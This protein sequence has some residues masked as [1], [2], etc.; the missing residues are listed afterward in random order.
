[1]GKDTGSNRK[2]GRAG[3]GGATNADV[4]KKDSSKPKAIGGLWFDDDAGVYR[5][6]FGAAVPD[7]K[8]QKI[9]L[10]SNHS[11]SKYKNG[12]TIS[13]SVAAEA[14]KVSINNGVD[15]GMLMGNSTPLR[16]TKST[17]TT[18]YPH[19]LINSATGGVV[20][21]GKT[22]QSLLDFAADMVYSVYE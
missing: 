10:K 22:R 5:D 18:V 2:S 17:L 19:R 21:T 8:G 16:I 14:N 3:G 9:P 11:A 12:V 20:A 4:G 7:F 13:A 1:M 6:N 15:K